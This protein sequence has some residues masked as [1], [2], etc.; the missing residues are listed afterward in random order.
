VLRRMQ[1]TEEAPPQDVVEE[2]HE[3]VDDLEHE[4]APLPR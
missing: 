4:S 3:L 2:V 1:E